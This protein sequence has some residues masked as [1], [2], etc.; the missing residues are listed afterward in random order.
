MNKIE[1]SGEFFSGTRAELVAAVKQS[2]S[3]HRFQHVLRV[4]QAAIKLAKLNDVSTEKASIAALTHDYSKERSDSE[5]K[6][7]IKKYS[8]DPDLLN[9]GNF[10]WHGV[11]GAQI[12]S[13]ELGITDPEIL[14][15]ISRHTVGAPKMAKLDQLIYVADFVEDGR[16]FPDAQIARSLAYADLQAAVIFETKHTLQYLMSSN[17]T[18]Y[19]VAIQ[20][21][22]AWVAGH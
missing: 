12:V 13:H 4:E 8:M 11:V 20:T 18:I 6:E 16:D 1:Y 9:W 15:A 3:E 5:F 14:N 17:K 19:P 2:L 22:N 7:T 21:Y 10:I